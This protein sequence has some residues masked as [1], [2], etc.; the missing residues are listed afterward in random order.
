MFNICIILASDLTVLLS[1]RG[2]CMLI[3]G[4]DMIL[5][6]KSG[7]FIKFFKIYLPAL[8]S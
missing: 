4:L 8:D 2:R 6:P 7:N 1:L 3:R 5:L